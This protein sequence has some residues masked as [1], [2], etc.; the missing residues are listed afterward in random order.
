MA[1]R[2]QL[3]AVFVSV[4]MLTLVLPACD[5]PSKETSV[6]A[7]ERSDA[8]TVEGEGGSATAVE[9]YQK[10]RSMVARDGERSEVRVKVT[11]EQPEKGDADTASEVSQAAVTDESAKTGQPGIPDDAPDLSS[12]QGGKVS[13]RVDESAAKAEE[14]AAKVEV[15]AA[16]AIEAEAAVQPARDTVHVVKAGESLYRLARK[17]GVRWEDLARH[18]KIP[19]PYTIHEGLEIRIPRDEGA[20]GITEKKGQEIAHYTVK[21]G[22]TL[23]SIASSF[24]VRWVEIAKANGIEDPSRLSLGQVLKIPPKETPKPAP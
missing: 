15:P 23:S 12:A 5:R 21:K 4:L 6:P 17:Y 19:P 22:D 8:E 24:G 20:E 16:G 2:R 3:A 10:L 7:P 9:R 1:P 11:Q 13:A 18:N 14:V